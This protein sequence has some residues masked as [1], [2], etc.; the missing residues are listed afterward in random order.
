MSNPLSRFVL[1][2]E[3]GGWRAGT[4]RVAELLVGLFLYGVAIVF[5]I[6]GAL[7]VGPWDVFSLGLV[8][9]TGWSYGIA[10]IVISFG[11]LLLWIPL[12][13]RLGLG[14]LA[15]AILVG[16]SADLAFL[17]IPAVDHLALQILFLAIGMVMLAFAT[18]LY[19]GADFGPG[20]RD[21]LMTGLRRVT[22][23][24]L[25]IVRTII[26]GSALLIGWLLGGPVGIGT[27]I[28][29]FGIGPLI[30]L[31]FPYFERRAAR[32][33]QARS[34]GMGDAPRA[35]ATDATNSEG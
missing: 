7:G 34:A 21:G 4:A 10:T 20:P 32:R 24:P 6:R 16:L 11:V 19:I 31:F 17:F 35:T 13:Q 8:K 23:W 29:A 27:L 22:G 25:W 5:F 3:F 18:G 9:Q 1:P 30:Q 2:V 26:E 15:N 14:T 33:R 12:R 28:F